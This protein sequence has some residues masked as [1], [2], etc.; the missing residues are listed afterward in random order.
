M[1]RLDD[2]RQKLVA[3]AHRP[4]HR[5]AASAAP[6]RRARA[7]RRRQRAEQ[8]FSTSTSIM[9]RSAATAACFHQC[10]PRVG[11]PENMSATR[12]IQ[13]RPVPFVW[14]SIPLPA[15]MHLWT[16]FL[17]HRIGILD[18]ESIQYGDFVRFHHLRVCGL[19]VIVAA[20]MQHA[21]NDEVRQVVRRAF[22]L[23]GRP[24]ARRP[25]RRRRRRPS[26]VARA[27]VRL[28]R[29]R[30]HVGRAVAV[31]EAR[32]EI[33]HLVGADDRMHSA[34]DR[35]MRVE[36]SRAAQR[37]TR[38]PGRPAHLDALL[39]D[40]GSTP[41]GRYSAASPSDCVARGGSRRASPRATRRTP[42]RLRRSAARADG[43]RRP[44]TLKCVK[45]QALDAVEHVAA[46]ES[47]PDR[48]PRGRSICVMSPVIT[49]V[50]PKPMRVRNIFI[51]SIV[52]F[53]LSSRMMN[54]LFNVRPRMYASGATSMTLR[55][56]YL[57]HAFDAH[58]LV[59]RVVQR[60]QI[61]ID[62]LREVAGQEA[63]LFARLHRGPHQQ[64][65][66]DALLLER[67]RPHTRPRDTSCRCRRGR[68][69]S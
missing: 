32:V 37:R 58:H 29:E 16:A 23:R 61:R 57:V 55:S 39:V 45:R 49:A 64:N 1:L 42:H 67:R 41:V 11:S 7:C 52:V 69:R 68:C 22:A 53:W 40:P 8:M 18:P 44:S 5:R 59:Q 38:H 56:M 4:S 33:R 62:L 46:R 63:E 60:P 9:S 6:S 34:P 24:R 47:S 31:A 10:L 13:R 54:A 28:G 48:L 66:A 19:H 27:R 65:A 3:A 30:Q 35:P 2:D 20:Q 26:C 36:R 51:C 21:M 25:A 50:E 43:A 12:S 14:L 17:R 15:G